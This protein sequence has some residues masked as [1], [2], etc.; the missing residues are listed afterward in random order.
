MHVAFRCDASF[1]I[2]SGHEMRFLTL[3]TALRDFGH[4]CQFIY[5]DLRG[6]MVEIVANSGFP[7]ALLPKL[8]P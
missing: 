2:G 5:R 1:E 8:L 7:V 4:S 6:H 3:A